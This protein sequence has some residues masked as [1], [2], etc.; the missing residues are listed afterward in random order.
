MATCRNVYLSFWTDTKVCDQFSPEDKYFMLYLLTNK[1]ANLCGCYKIS[2]GQIASDLGYNKDSVER[3][4]ER[5]DKEYDIAR[6]DNATSELFVRNWHKYNWTSSPKLDSALFEEIE[7]IKNDEFHDCLVGIFNERRTA[8]TKLGY[9][10][11]TVSIPYPYG[12]NTVSDS[13]NDDSLSGIYINK[14]VSNESISN[15]LTQ[16]STEQVT[17]QETNNSLYINNQKDNDKEKIQKKKTDSSQSQDLQEE[18][19]ISNT[20]LYLNAKINGRYVSSAESN[21]KFI[22]ARLREG[23]TFD[24]FKRVIDNQ[25]IKW[26]DTD[27]AEYM[28]PETLFNATK[29]Q[30]YINAPDYSKVKPKPTGEP[31]GGV[32]RITPDFFTKLAK[33]HKENDT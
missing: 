32:T 26:K 31:K 30:S 8:K 4:L 17:T 13:E 16:S 27:M 12:I 10:I 25:W 11:H 23:Y 28:R 7:S 14:H 6:F 2:M 5:F 18:S 1:Y 3:I 19:T 15:V 20:V 22:R 21:R 24:D 29:F 33:E 9:R